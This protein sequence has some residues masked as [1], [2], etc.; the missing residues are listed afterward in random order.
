M[1]AEEHCDETICNPVEQFILAFL[2]LC[3][4]QSR[5]RSRIS[6]TTTTFRLPFWLFATIV[7]V[8]CVS[9]TIFTLFVV[10]SLKL[11]FPAG[12]FYPF[13]IDKKLK[14]PDEKSVRQK[15]ALTTGPI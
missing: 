12:L 5:G 14:G 11:T 8:R 15:I 7:I 3:L 2:D 6:I 13:S 4:S 10:L 9:T 1:N